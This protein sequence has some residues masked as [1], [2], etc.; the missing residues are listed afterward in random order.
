MENLFSRYRNISILVGVLFLQILGLAIQVHRVKENESTLLIRVWTYGAI[1]PLEKG[2]VGLQHGVGNIWRNYIYLHGVR[3]ENRDLKEE[4]QQLRLK[5]VRMSQDAQQAH[6]LQALLAF[7]ER[8]LSQTTAAQVIGSG[9]SEQSRVIYIDKGRDANLEAEMPVITA[10]GIVGKIT[11]VDARSAQVLLIN[12]QTSG[13]GAVLEDSRL[14]GVLRGTASGRLILD[15]VALEEQVQAGEHVLTSGGDGIFPKGLPVGVVSDVSKGKDSFLDIHIRPS[16]DLNKLEEV[17]VITKQEEAVPS[18]A[19]TG[20][21]ASDILARR[22]PSVPQQPA[23][24]PVQKPAAS[25]VKTAASPAPAGGTVAKTPG[26]AASV[27]ELKPA[28]ENTA[29]PEQ[30][31]R[32]AHIAPASPAGT[33]TQGNAETVVRTITDQSSAP[34]P[35]KAVQKNAGDDAVKPAT[36]D[37]TP[38]ED[39]QQ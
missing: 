30:D 29:T 9:G 20:V 11:R 3:Q 6:R 4:I 14:Q 10:E 31:T 5:E 18:F 13:A 38:P 12:D 7:K 35:M 16:A 25:A 15:K 39:K 2:I 27:P 1:S 33:G 23:N 21:R 28:K 22:L 8:Y 34:A 24:G 32:G 19:E 26:Q 17:L 36:T 37:S